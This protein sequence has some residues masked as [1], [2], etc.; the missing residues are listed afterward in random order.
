MKHELKNKFR[1]LFIL[2]YDLQKK[3]FGGKVRPYGTPLDR[4]I[5]PSKSSGDYLRVTL[6][7]GNFQAKLYKLNCS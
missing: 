6:A 4:K 1:V 2:F 5:K 3:G 7:R